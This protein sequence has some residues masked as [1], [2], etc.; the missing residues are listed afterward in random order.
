MFPG[1]GHRESLLT[2]T[3]RA[4]WDLQSFL[5]KWVMQEFSE[6]EQGTGMLLVR[7]EKSL[8][9][10]QLLSAISGCS[11]GA[12]TSE[13]GPAPRPCQNHMEPTRAAGG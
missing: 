6:T 12:K 7:L 8:P 10:K 5:A 4:S 11:P 13:Q 2:S 1:L 3:E 9:H